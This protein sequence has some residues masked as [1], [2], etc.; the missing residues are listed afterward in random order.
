MFVLSTVVIPKY[1]ISTVLAAVFYTHSA[2]VVL[3]L[4]AL[5]SRPLVLQLFSEIFSDGLCG[6][7]HPISQWGFFFVLIGLNCD[8]IKLFLSGDGV[9]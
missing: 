7:S 1:V 8:S 6:M 2:A 4:S 5:A 9:F 3:S